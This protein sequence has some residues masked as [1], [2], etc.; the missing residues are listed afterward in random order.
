V[1][2][3][4]KGLLVGV[5][6]LGAVATATAQP[7]T[8]VDDIET[9]LIK[10]ADE[11]LVERTYGALA[12]Q[13][14]A[15][16]Q[17]GFSLFSHAELR[18]WQRVLAPAAKQLVEMLA[19]DGGLEW[20]DQNG[21]TEKT[22]TPRQEA[23]RAL[24]ALERASVEPLIAVLDRLP[25]AR[26]A[27]DL[28][29]QIVRGGPTARDRVAWQSWWTAHQNQPLHNERGQWYLPAIGLVALA[30]VGALVFRRQRASAS[31]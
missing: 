20:I 21:M 1:V 28:L 5:L 24:L 29:R 10:L 12:A 9:I 18:P 7:S 30:G 4:T 15:K 23:A 13:H 14:F 22:T 3:A 6:L 2:V 19:E 27:D 16:K 11:D 8:P 25:L 17:W 31:S 26:K